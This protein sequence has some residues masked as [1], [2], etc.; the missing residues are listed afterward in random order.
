MSSQYPLVNRITFGAGGSL[1]EVDR[2]SAGMGLNLTC[3][4]AR[5]P[6]K[7][8]DGNGNLQLVSGPGADRV[9]VQIRGTGRTVPSLAGQNLAAL[10]TVIYWGSGSTTTLNLCTLGIESRESDL[11][12]ATTQWTLEGVGT[13][14]AGLDPLGR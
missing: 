2:V 4:P 5:M 3:A 9:R 1:V 11:P 12:G 7:V 13:V 14:T 8:Y 6:G 10:V